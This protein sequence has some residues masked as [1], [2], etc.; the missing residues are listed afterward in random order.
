VELKRY[1]SRELAKN[2]Q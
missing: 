1:K 2:K